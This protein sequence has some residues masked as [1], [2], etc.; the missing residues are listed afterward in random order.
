MVVTPEKKGGLQKYEINLESKRVSVVE[1]IDTTQ[2][3]F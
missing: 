3:G 2:T 1:R